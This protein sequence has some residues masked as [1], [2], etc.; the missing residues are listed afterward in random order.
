MKVTDLRKY[1]KDKSDKELIDELVAIYKLSAFNK[2]YFRVRI[3]DGYEEEVF[4]NYKYHLGKLFKP[5]SKNYLSTSQLSQMIN[6][7]KKLSTSPKLVIELMLYVVE[8][9]IVLLID[10]PLLGFNIYGYT[11]KLY[12]KALKEIVK[13]NLQNQFRNQCNLLMMSLENDSSSHTTLYYCYYKYLGEEI[14]E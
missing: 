10:Y 14:I 6:D 8:K 12:E 11:A 13:H 7:F 2:E 5:S 4:E 1:L 9:G 3:E